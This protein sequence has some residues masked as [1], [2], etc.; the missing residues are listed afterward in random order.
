MITKDRKIKGWFTRTT[1][2]QGHTQAQCF[3][4]SIA[5]LGNSQ[6][7]LTEYICLFLCPPTRN[8]SISLVLVFALSR[9]TS[10]GRRKEFLFLILALVLTSSRFTRTFSCAYAYACVVRACKPA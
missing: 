4:I 2:T 7:R 8:T 6:S 1:Q 10:A 3:S 5:I 9:F